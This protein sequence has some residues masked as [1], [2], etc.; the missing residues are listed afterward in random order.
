MIGWLLD[1][2]VVS[3]IARADGDAKVA[4]WAGG[5]DEDCLFISILT[6]AEYDKGVHNLPADAPGRARIEASITALEARFTGRI[7]SLSDSIVRRWGRISGALQRSTGK[8]P[9]VIDTLLAATAIEHDL[10]LATRNVVDV[11]ET[12]AAVFNPWHD[13]P[14]SFPLT[15]RFVLR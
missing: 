12:G 10:Y 9:Q 15:R 11:R 1:T 4:A 7:L 8:A 3:E 2:N 14:A 6:L 13:D 5:Q